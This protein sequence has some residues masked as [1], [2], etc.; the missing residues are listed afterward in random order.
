MTLDK[1]YKK[2]MD[3]WIQKI[4]RDINSLKKTVSTLTKINIR[5]SKVVTS[6]RKS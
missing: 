5:L 2:E 6:G 1:E 4:E 3:Y